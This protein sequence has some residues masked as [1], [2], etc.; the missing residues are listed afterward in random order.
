MRFAVRCAPRCRGCTSSSLAGYDD[1]AYAK[2]AISIG[3]KEYLLKPVSLQELHKVLAR[4]AEAIRAE[5]QQQANLR[6]YPD[7][8][9]SS[10]ELLKQKLLERSD[11]GRARRRRSSDARGRCT[12]G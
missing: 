1:F 12:R 11:L 5:K 7:Q 9:A 3:V 10:S 4:M 6:I 2:E 8:L